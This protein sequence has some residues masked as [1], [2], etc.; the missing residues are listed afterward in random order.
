[1]PDQT[2]T[3]AS[4]QTLAGIGG[5][6]GS[7]VVSNGATLTPAGT[8]TTIGITTGSNPVGA[9]AASTSITLNGTTV[10]KLDGTSNDVIEAAANIMYG[11]TLN[12]ANISGAPLTAGN[13]FQ[14]FNAATY[15]GSFSSITPATPGSGLTWNTSQLSSGI[16]SVVGGPNGPV[17]GS[18]KV[19]GGNFIFSGSGGVTNGTYYVLTSTNLLTPLPGWTPIATNMYDGS[20]NFSV[21]NPLSASN[22]QR[23]YIIKQ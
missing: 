10:I 2:L 16:I 5:I 18:A 12:L 23:F 9:I 4:G 13:S 19:A 15:S 11:G 21:T 6:N 7:L 8:N 20:G 17:V 3:L 22:H 1:R 14:I